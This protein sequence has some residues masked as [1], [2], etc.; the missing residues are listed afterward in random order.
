MFDLIQQQALIRPQA[1]ALDSPEISLDYATLVRAVARLAGQLRAQRVSRLGL[2]MDN[3]PAWAVVD[4]ASQLAGIT[5]IP[6]PPFFS[7]QQIEHTLENAQI[8]HLLVDDHDLLK[9][10]GSNTELLSVAGLTLALVEINPAGE[11]M[12]EVST[13]TYTSGTTGHPK[14]VC[15]TQKNL[16]QVAAALAGALAVNSDDHHLCLL[17]LAVLLENV[18]GL[19]AP[20]LSGGRVTILPLKMCGVQ[21]AAG[22]DVAQMYQTICQ[23][24]PTSLILLPQMLQALVGYLEVGHR[25]P[26]SLRFIAVGG[27]P[28]SDTLLA[29][30]AALDLPVY[31]GYGLSECGSVVALNTPQSHSLGS[32]GKP[33]PH[34][35][36]R[37]SDEGEIF[38]RGNLFAGYLN[39]PEQRQQWYASGDLGYLDQ[40]G[41]LHLTGRKKNIFITAFG[42]N[43]APE[44]VERELTIHPAIA[45]AAVFGEAQPFNVA[46]L[47]PRGEQSHAEIERAVAWANQRLPD[48]AQIREWLCVAT[49]FSI[50]NQ[51]LT[52]TG[53]LRREAIWRQYQTTIESYY[54]TAGAVSKEAS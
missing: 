32:V 30:A 9:W 53:R 46:L 54:Q 51:Q 27:A 52:A 31:E 6:I 21:G 4:L 48:Y 5:L 43:V 50:S 49:P 18:G 13:I 26:G 34:I 40:Q 44:W 2:L 41:F 20:L 14:G 42:R 1:L 47:V 35:Q 17:P 36:L 10:Q 39:Q 25:V 38:I 15:L 8:D 23:V 29:R 22:L 16:H 11:P 19:Y 28:V 24:E 45:Q 3:H 33:L 12:G 7:S 37:F